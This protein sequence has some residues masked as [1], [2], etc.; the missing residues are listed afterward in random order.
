MRADRQTDMLIAIFRT[1]TGRGKNLACGALSFLV[2]RDRLFLLTGV[3]DTDGCLSVCASVCLS[4]A[5]FPYYCTDPDVTWGN[6]RG[7]R[8][9]CVANLQSV[10]GFRSDDNIHVCKPIAL[11]T[12]NAYSAEREM[13]ASAFAR[14]IAG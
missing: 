5:A 6:G 11:C 13:S 14:S 10:H 2:W 1:C 4:F 9:S 3:A 12:A 7:D 8:Y